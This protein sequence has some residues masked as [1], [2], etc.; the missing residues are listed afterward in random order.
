MPRPQA[1]LFV[2]DGQARVL[3]WSEW[4]RRLLGRAAEDVVG[5]PALPML[6]KEPED[7]APSPGDRGDAWYVRRVP[8]DSAG[9]EWGVWPAGPTEPDGLDDAVLDAVFTQSAVGLHVLDTDLRVVRVNTVAV[10]MRGVPEDSIVGR[11]V[12][13]AY[14]GLSDDVVES[15][16]REVLETGRPSR[17]VLVR[18]YPRV[19]PGREHVFSTSAFRLQ[20]RTGRPLGVV[21]TAVDVTERERAQARLR[22]LRTAHE[23]IGRSLDVLHTA[24]ELV[25]V[26]VPAFADG[27]LVALTDSVL[28]GKA[29]E[30]LPREISPLLRCAAVAGA[31]W[32][33]PEPGAIL[34]PGLFGGELPAKPALVP[35]PSPD[36]SDG[37]GLSGQVSLVVPLTARGQIFGV[38][39]F[40]RAA[41]AE[42]FEPDD[43]T[44][45]DGIAARTATCLENALRFT[46]EHIVMTALQ[47]R[48]QRQEAA[49]HRAVE[50]AQGHRADGGGAGA[51]CD[52]I[53]LSGARVALVV[54]QVQ[55][56]GISGVATMSQLRTAVHSLAG[57]DLEPHELLARLH[58]TTLRLAAEQG[59]ASVADA[60]TASCAFA[61]HDPV[62]GR[63]DIA[64][65]GMSLLC[66]VRP[67]GSVDPAPVPAGPLLGAEG[68]PFPCG[69]EVLPAGSTL[70]VASQPL[71]SR[72]VA[73][74]ERLVE[75]LAHPGQSPRSMADEV[76]KILAEDAVVL[77]ARTRHLPADELAEW[78][79]P[80]EPSAVRQTRRDVEQRL[81]EWGVDVDPFSVQLVVSELVT[82]AVRYG[83]APITL[84]L[85]RGEDS[86]ICE[87]SDAALTAPYLR[88]AKANEEGG[89]GLHICASVT[90]SWGVRYSDTDKTVWTE[91]A[92]GG[93]GPTA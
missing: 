74:T 73:S 42:P 60:P 34:L 29:P 6:S 13:E 40:R 21:A 19:D 57:L 28:R 36:A 27:I 44:L 46:R 38:V 65:A 62:A 55:Q 45:A 93:T 59:E 84:R 17:D 30:T 76:E 61:V 26:T 24:Q 8:G 56:P 33:P 18:A 39:A 3:C 82:N 22:L 72:G 58:A 53:P 43:L 49:T 31:H 25:D 71:S 11:S 78:H 77:I 2:M 16:V 5:T 48:P 92:V 37:D 52:V 91:I 32:Q 81:E 47:G 1:P 23:T 79:V 85:L 86:L 20:D 7:A 12:T 51:W 90:E 63:L 66:L 35:S 4:A 89:R 15:T 50:I 67:D 75:A 88:H 10:G 70:C 14:A 9:P 87:V 69:S 54:G 41:G 64:R 83:E 80:A 68:P